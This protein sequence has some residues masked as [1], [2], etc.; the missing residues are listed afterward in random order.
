MPLR[1]EHTPS[2]A[3]VKPATPLQARAKLHPWSWAQPCL[4][5]PPCSRCVPHWTR[6]DPGGCPS[7]LATSPHEP[8][9]AAP[10]S[11][12]GHFQTLLLVPRRGTWGSQAGRREA[13]TPRGIQLT[14]LRV[15]QAHAGGPARAQ[16]AALA[17]TL[18]GGVDCSMP[19]SCALRPCTAGPCR[20]SAPDLCPSFRSGTQ[21]RKRRGGGDHG[22]AFNN[23]SGG[24]GGGQGG[25]GGGGGGGWNGG[26]GNAFS[27]DASAYVTWNL[28][29]ALTLAACV[30]HACVT[31]RSDQEGA[32]RCLTWELLTRQL[33]THDR[34]PLLSG[35]QR[36]CERRAEH[37]AADGVR[38]PPHT[39]CTIPL[40]R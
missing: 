2:R 16:F 32:L 11:P 1:E 5:G 28:L 36:P 20:V 23:D 21:K 7:L 24:G 14:T 22:R 30:Q 10:L 34:A 35:A 8:S 4:C 9:C 17:A 29:C 37:A 40:F 19:P 13:A 6:R 38:A 27:D 3:F 26:E 18:A 25:W 31:V 15:T 33:L 12:A 39:R